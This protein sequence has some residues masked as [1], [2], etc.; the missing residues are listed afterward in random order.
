MQPNPDTPQPSILHQP[1][2]H[3]ASSTLSIYIA[4][5]SAL[6]VSPRRSPRFEVARLSPHQKSLGLI[7]ARSRILALSILMGLG[8]LLSSCGSPTPSKSTAVPNPPPPT[9]PPPQATQAGNIT[10]SPQYIALG[11]GQK[12]AFQA[13][14]PSAETLQWSVNGVVG[15]N[16][17]A[18]TIDTAGNYT[19]PLTVNYGANVV[20]SVADVSAPKT[21]YASAV[22]AVLAPGVVTKTANPQVAT[23]SIYLPAPGKVSIDFGPDTTYSLNSWQQATPSPYGGEVS[24]YVAGMRAQTLYHMRAV[25]NLDSGASYND[26]DQTF[27]TGTPPGTAPVTITATTGQNPQPGIEMFDTALPH[28]SAQ[29]FATDLQGNVIW[30]Y[31]YN[32]GTTQDIVQPIKLLPNGHFLVLISYASSAVLNGA[33]IQPATIDVVREIDLAGNTIRE[34]TLS[35]LS[36]ALAAKGYNLNLGSF[37]HDI[38]A[39]PNGHW[40]LLASL[41]Q[42]FSNLPGSSGPTKVLGDVLIDVDQNNQPVWV[43]NTFDHLDINRHPYLFPDWTHANA[44]L[45]SADDHNLILSMR[46]QNWIIKIDYQDGQGSGNVLWHL[47]EGGD[48][49]LKNGVDPTDWFYSQH[50]PAFFTPNTTG[51]FRLGVMDN[52]DDRPTPDGGLCGTTGEPACYSTAMVLQLDE[53]A[54]TATLVNHYNPSPALYSY[55]GGDVRPLPNGNL[56]ADFCALKGGALVQELD[57]N[58][59]TPQLVWQAE[60]KTTLQYRAKRMPSLY[61]GVQW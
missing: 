46:H 50:G 19:A 22:A 1:E 2:N 52:G 25:V 18:G 21:N 17:Q 45:Y 23:Y 26:L 31:A 10:I 3:S 11:A 12:Q 54:M 42:S 16:S 29:A 57:L 56:E 4:R 34:I 47:G 32:T 44:L 43:W 5:G 8:L 58:G 24:I 14:A 49:A 13:T 20:I 40:I 35:S 6:S 7:T 53:S 38:L 33:T 59:A 41:Y 61:P 48:F 39:L 37:H 36:A 51:F 27:T 60:T 55:F 30:T 9:Q 28:E 15:G